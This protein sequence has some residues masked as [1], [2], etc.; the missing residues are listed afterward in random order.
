MHYQKKNITE[1]KAFPCYELVASLFYLTL[2]FWMKR[3]WVQ[4]SSAHSSNNLPL[5]PSSTHNHFL[6]PHWRVNIYLL[7]YSSCS[8]PLIT[9]IILCW[10][11]FF[12]LRWRTSWHLRHRESW[13]KFEAYC[14]C[15][16]A[17]WFLFLTSGPVML[18][19]LLFWLYSNFQCIDCQVRG[20]KPLKSRTKPKTK[21]C[22]HH[23]SVAQTSIRFQR[24]KMQ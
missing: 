4:S 19:H 3:V 1:S 5:L 10:T 8:M 23:T 18:I 16:T 20:K 14:L 11:F 17:A 12:P 24:L 15:F 13:R 21:M 7:L 2:F 6:S 22:L 9:F